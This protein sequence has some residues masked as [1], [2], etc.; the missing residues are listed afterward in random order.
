MQGLSIG[1]MGGS[2][3]LQSHSHENEHPNNAHVSTAKPDQPKETVPK[4][5][6]WASIASQP[7]KPQIRVKYF[8]TLNLNYDHYNPIFYYNF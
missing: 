6:T 2:S 7:A 4:K 8:S 5:M 1:G 3:N